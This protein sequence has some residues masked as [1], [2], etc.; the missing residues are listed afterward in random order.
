MFFERYRDPR[1][2]RERR[3]SRLINADHAAMAN[4]PQQARHHEFPRSSYIYNHYLDDGIHDPYF[5]RS[6]HTMVT[7]EIEKV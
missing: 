1:R 3:D 7:I 4:M 2:S 6:M 5:D